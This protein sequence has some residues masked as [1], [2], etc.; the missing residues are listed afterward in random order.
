MGVTEVDNMLMI[1]GISEK[2][3][4]DIRDKVVNMIIRG[5]FDTAK[6]AGTVVTGGQTI[7]NPWFL[8][9]G[10]ASSVSH[11]S[12]ILKP[13]NSVVGDVLVLTKPLGTRA[14]V[15]AHLALYEEAKRE[16][17]LAK[18][19]EENVIDC[20]NTAIKSMIRL[21]RNAA[22]LMKKYHANAATDV[23]GFG[24]LGHAD[25]L[26]RNQ[27]KK[28]KFR[29]DKLPFFKHCLAL[30]DALGFGLLYGKS[31]ETSGGLLVSM[32]RNN[33]E[34]FMKELFE[35]D[36]CK[37][38][39]VGTVEDVGSDYSGLNYAYLSDSLEAVEDV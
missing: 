27:T 24:I 3:E 16:K 23:T 5:Y 4:L 10:V 36:G 37:S 28:L 38:F 26:A 29:L 12:E 18:A 22:I 13:V 8:L 15:N 25:Q 1:L 32:S 35:V 9:G 39:I 20:Y 21:N 6:D 30:E 17:L 11:N 34:E 7:R 31:A 33:A 14:A 19:T 2:L